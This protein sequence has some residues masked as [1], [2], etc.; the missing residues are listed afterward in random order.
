MLSVLHTLGWI[1]GI[2][3]KT[4]PLYWLMIHPCVKYWRSRKWSPYRAL[5]PLWCLSWTLLAVVTCPWARVSPVLDDTDL[6]SLDATLCLWSLALL[7]FERGFQ[8]SAT[9]WLSLSASTER[10]R[11]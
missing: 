1:A 6:A 7:V 3:Y 2:T 8:Q 11:D 10:K 4:I 9:G 5:L